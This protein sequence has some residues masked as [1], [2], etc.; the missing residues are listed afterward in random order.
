MNGGDQYRLRDIDKKIQQNFWPPRGALSSALRQP[1]K[2]VK[3]ILAPQLLLKLLLSRTTW[4]KLSLLLTNHFFKYIHSDSGYT[5]TVHT[6][7]SI[8]YTTLTYIMYKFQS[9]AW[10]LQSVFNRDFMGQTVPVRLK[11]MT[12][13]LTSSVL[14]HYHLS[15]RSWMLI[16]TFTFGCCQQPFWESNLAT[17]KA[18]NPMKQ[19]STSWITVTRYRDPLW[20]YHSPF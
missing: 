7:K 9:K 17:L 16:V 6:R 13:W 3:P 4:R 2:L 1:L 12:F 15:I 20:K 10:M 14:V 19:C 5:A 8:H 18:H 11:P